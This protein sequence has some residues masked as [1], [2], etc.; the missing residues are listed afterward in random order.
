MILQNEV[1]MVTENNRYYNTE[2]LNGDNVVVEEILSQPYKG[3]VVDNLPVKIFHNIS[4]FLNYI[5]K[6]LP[7]FSFLCIDFLFFFKRRI[8]KIELNLIFNIS[9]KLKQYGND[10]TYY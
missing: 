6:M 9:I 8:N 3:N 4:I 7:T 2:L 1:L 10:W 5:Y